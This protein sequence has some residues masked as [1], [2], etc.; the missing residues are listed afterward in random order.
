MVLTN[1]L[2]YSRDPTHPSYCFSAFS[3]LFK[4]STRS[5]TFTEIQRSACI[6]DP[7]SVFLPLRIFPFLFN[8]DTAQILVSTML[9]VVISVL[10][11]VVL[12]KPIEKGRQQ[13]LVVGNPSGLQEIPGGSIVKLCSGSRDTNILA[14]SR[15]VNSP[16]VPIL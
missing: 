5:T 8:H 6:S 7:Q 3:V 12:G 9:L 4:H 2:Y 10:H 16:Q 1:T 14:I 13:P 15:I 11:A